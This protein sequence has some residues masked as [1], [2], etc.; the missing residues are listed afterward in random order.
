MQRAPLERAGG[1]VPLPLQDLNQLPHAAVRRL[2]A[3]RREVAAEV[4]A[5]LIGSVPLNPELAAAGDAGRPVAE[6]DGPLA[7]VF[8]S[9]AARV[10]KDVAPPI[11]SAG[12]SARLLD[13]VEKAVEAGSAAS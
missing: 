2:A 10:V 3:A 13:A 7:A 11:D 9:L 1:D 8:E 6:G 5:P 12:C 4:G